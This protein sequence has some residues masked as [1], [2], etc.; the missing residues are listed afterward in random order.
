[1]TPVPVAALA[2]LGML[3]SWVWSSLPKVRTSRLRP[4]VET[5]TA[6]SGP[7]DGPFFDLYKTSFRAHEV[8]IVHLKTEE[9][10]IE[11]MAR[12]NSNVVSSTT[13]FSSETSEAVPGAIA[14]APLAAGAGESQRLAAAAHVVPITDILIVNVSHKEVIPPDY[15]QIKEGVNRWGRKMYICYRKRPGGRPVTDI[16]MI[17]SDSRGKRI[18]EECPEGLPISTLTIALTL[19]RL[20]P[21]PS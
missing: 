18:A 11:E 2:V 10:L 12:K 20:H 13:A 1:M 8:P 19:P 16:R 7:P 14:S 5:M 15:T 4:L 6:G 9:E 3:T 17:Y 21:G